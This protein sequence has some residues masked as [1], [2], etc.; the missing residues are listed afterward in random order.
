MNL[1]WLTAVYIGGIILANI[2][3]QPS[4]GL[5]FGVALLLLAAWLLLR[6][7][8]W[9]GCAILLATAL[10]GWTLSG[11]A[12]QPPPDPQHIVHFTGDHYQVLEGRL[13]DL[14]TYPDG[15]SRFDLGV[16]RVFRTQSTTPATGRVRVSVGQG[17]IPAGEGQKVRLRVRLRTPR[18]FGCPGEFDYTGHLASQ[19]IYATTFIQDASQIIPIIEEDRGGPGVL[20]SL[21]DTIA[22]QIEQNVCTEEAGLVQALL[23]GQRQG[24]SPHQRTLLSE[25][26]VSHLF[27]IS[28]LH[29]GLLGLLLYAISR[30][31]YCQST[32]LMLWCPP[33]RIVPLL[34]IAPMGLYLLLTGNALP[35]RRAFCMA[36]LAAL[37]YSSNRR[38]PPTQLL[39]ATALLILL[40]QP[41]AL[42]R[43]AF[44]L[45][46]AGLFGIL[47]WMPVWQKRLSDAPAWLRWPTAILLTTLAATLATAP[48]VLWHFHLFAPAGLPA[49]L[50]AT[51]LIAW[52]ALPVG[53]TGILLLPI[54]PQCADIFFSGSGAL[55]A[56]ALYLVE[57]LTKLPG[58]AAW[59]YFPGWLDMLALAV[60]LAGMLV[61]STFRH[62][63]ILR[64]AALLCGMCLLLFRPGGYPA[65]QVV[66]LSVG[67]GDATLLSFR[68]TDHYLIDGG[69]LPGSN[70]DPGERLVA[71]ALGRLHVRRLRG[72]ILTHDHPDHRA[73][74]RFILQTLPVDRFYSA[75]PLQELDAELRTVLLNRKV[76]CTLLPEGW[77]QFAS[78]TET[79][80]RVFTPSQTPRDKNERSL[81]VYAGLKREGVL[82][83]GD[84]GP[85][86]LRQLLATELPGPVTLLKLPHHGSRKPSPV[87]YLSTIMP[88]CTFVS[89]GRH[90]PYH[91]PAS[92]TLS[93]LTKAGIPLHRTDL[94]GT[95]FFWTAGEGWYGPNNPGRLFD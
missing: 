74:L 20:A 78:P 39:T 33:R 26:G 72:V 88:Q 48:L 66:A 58:L 9:G 38:T 93:Q 92:A 23:I 68:G 32:H 1:C 14:V 13:H 63:H 60:L 69:G 44:Q 65:L 90:N 51:P 82:L 83:T 91:L 17:V 30:K 21:R 8:R 67:Q 42:F 56:L 89:V 22:R 31:L 80:L 52:G 64:A 3:T 4:A 61:R 87:N 6:T 37:L 84:M 34:L 57:Q 10:L 16:S 85:A 62:R 79:D 46:F 45:S 15:R 54:A 12:L 95:L 73:G 5:I 76:P 50:V 81:I 19:G 28:G 2:V 59:H 94:Q 40:C 24:V 70:F 36:S 7:T 29:F 47:F 41:Q 43:P 27:A 49:N 25:G 86:G 77:T 75:I 11:I 55:V 53:L 35:T 18:N 71:P